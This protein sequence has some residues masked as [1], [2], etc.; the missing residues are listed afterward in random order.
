MSLD[1]N[2][3]INPITL[4]TDLEGHLIARD[5]RNFVGMCQVIKA[6]SMD[7][8]FQDKYKEAGDLISAFEKIFEDANRLPSEFLI[9]IIDV[10]PKNSANTLRLLGISD[11]LDK[12]ILCTKVDIPTL[13]VLRTS[14]FSYLL[15]WA[16]KN[17]KGQLVDQV[18]QHLSSIGLS[19]STGVDTRRL[20]ANDIVDA[21][22]E[23]DDFPVA[24]SPAVDQTIALLI[25]TQGHG[26]RHS[27][28]L[29]K[30]ALSG[31]H[32]TLM[33]MLVYGQI[34][35]SSLIQFSQ[36]STEKILAALPQI[37]TSMQLRAI[38]HFLSPEG[39]SEKIL[40][41]E[42]IDLDGYLAALS[43]SHYLGNLNGDLCFKGI[44]PFFW[45]M[46]PENV[47]VPAKRNRIKKL[48]N[49]TI[50]EQFSKGHMTVLDAPERLIRIGVPKHAL[51]LIDRLRGHELEDALGL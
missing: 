11:D 50:E 46:T 9:E 49:V 51:K 4:R 21:L 3:E 14:G 45:F 24:F 31:L 39:L 12:E 47:S 27:K 43:D 16:A 7:L 30:M 35:E 10:F 37:P 13:G 42:K 41:D 32:H 36:Q 15:S 1:F 8:I 33:K 28:Y 2:V 18:V 26:T 25:N 20:L 5:A 48:L 17:N 34:V 29:E 6:K 40:F 44:K 38:H 23:Q 19:P 22:L